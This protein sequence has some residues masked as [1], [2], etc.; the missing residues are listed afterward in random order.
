MHDSKIFKFRTNK[1]QNY[2]N[3][4][5]TFLQTKLEIERAYLGN[6]EVSNGNEE[7]PSGNDSVWRGYFHKTKC[8]D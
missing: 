1:T 4:E 7:S 6:P 3:S 5:H 2:S 8:L